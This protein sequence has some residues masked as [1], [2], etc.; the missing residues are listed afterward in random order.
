MY[1][2][3]TA[4]L[5]SGPGKSNHEEKSDKSKLKAILPNNWPSILKN[6][7]DLKLKESLRIYLRLKKTKG[8][9]K[10]CV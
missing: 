9:T 5:W 8:T 1:E 6:I 4:L 3:N 10:C 7:K 2:K